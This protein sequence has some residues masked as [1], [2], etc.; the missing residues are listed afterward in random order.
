MFEG[1][2]YTGFAAKPLCACCDL[3]NSCNHS[4]SGTSITTALL[5]EAIWRNWK[6]N[7]KLATK[8]NR[9]WMHSTGHLQNFTISYIFGCFGIENVDRKELGFSVTVVES[10]HH[11][12]QSRRLKN[13]TCQLW[14]LKQVGLMNSLQHYQ[15]HCAVRE[16]RKR[17]NRAGGRRWI[18][19]SP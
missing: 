11:K 12:F 3:C 1:V 10:N 4:R 8:C 9:W 18:N 7:Q 17:E 5:T 14:N 15:K 16:Q 6:L 2:A 13:R 19:R